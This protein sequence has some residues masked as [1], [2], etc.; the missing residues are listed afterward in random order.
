MMVAL[1]G[2]AAEPLLLSLEFCRCTS[3][4]H[5][6]RFPWAG[7]CGSFIAVSPSTREHVG[8]DMCQGQEFARREQRRACS[9]RL[10]RGW[11]GL[12]LKSQRELD[13]AASAT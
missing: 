7:E 6:A 9:L 11:D 4:S 10:L 1:L 5:A 3:P 8:S 2:D 13:A 12:S